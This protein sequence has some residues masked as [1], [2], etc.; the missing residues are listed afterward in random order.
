VVAAEYGYLGWLLWDPGSGLDSFVV[1]PAV[2][3]AI[4]AAGAV[5]LVFGRARAWLVL[6]VVSVL[7]LLGLL[8]LV[9]VFGALGGG[10]A[11]WQA[12]LLLIG[13]I[14]CLALTVRR[15]VREWSASAAGRRPGAERRPGGR[16]R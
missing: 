5:L 9:V 15:P 2:L 10:A 12:M 7:L 6:T 8:A 3:A 16:A 14:G 4:A 1:V 11:M 13:P